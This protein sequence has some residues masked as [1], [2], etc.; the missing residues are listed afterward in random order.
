MTDL[1][2]VRAGAGLLKARLKS[3]SVVVPRWCSVLWPGRVKTS[4]SSH[5]SA[6]QAFTG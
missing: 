5:F 3:E 4:I 1:G 6:I 2:L